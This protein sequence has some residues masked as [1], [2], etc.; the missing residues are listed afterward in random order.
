[1]GNGSECFG[2][3]DEISQDH[4]WGAD[5]FL[6]LTEA[7][8]ESAAALS[9]WKWKLFKQHPP[10]F[11]RKTSAY[12]A[13]IGVMTCA[14]FY[15]G[16]I[17]CPEGPKTMQEWYAAPEENFALAVNGEVFIDGAGEFAATRKLL[18]GYFPED[19]RRKR[20]AAKCMAVAQT[21]QYNLSRC[22]KRKDY[23][24][25]RIALARFTENFIA[26]VF[27]LNRVYRPYYKWAFKAMMELP[28]LGASA[29]ELL[30]KMA[31]TGGFDKNS[32]TAIKACIESLCSMAAQELRKQGLTSSTDSFFATLGEDVSLGIKDKA[33][34]CLPPQY[35]I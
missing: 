17:G 20:I 35:D 26:L 6:W 33:L 23:V 24:T 18:L 9:D 2:Y 28:V 10:A 4:D 7:D 22:L 29:G 31:A 11:V 27:L 15:A 5:F 21:G 14:E 1:M 8:R 12:G 30:G 25:A 13:K 32:V 19:L 34:R 3:D 16:L